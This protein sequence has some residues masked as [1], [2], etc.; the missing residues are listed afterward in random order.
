M[1][2]YRRIL[3]KLFFNFCLIISALTQQNAATPQ[4]TTPFKYT[5][6]ILILRSIHVVLQ[7]RKA[8]PKNNPY[9]VPLASAPTRFRAI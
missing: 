3:W 4:V 1:F 7:L 6:A 8:H 9:Q 5:S 2:V